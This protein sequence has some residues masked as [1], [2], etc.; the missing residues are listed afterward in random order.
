MCRAPHRSR[1]KKKKIIKK[2][3][4]S[5]CRNNLEGQDPFF[6]LIKKIHSMC[7]DCW[8][9][10]LPKSGFCIL[11]FHAKIKDFINRNTDPQWKNRFFL[12][13][14]WKYQWRIEYWIS[15]ALLSPPKTQ[16]QLNQLIYGSVHNFSFL[17]L[18]GS[19]QE[20]WRVFF[21][22]NDQIISKTFINSWHLLEQKETAPGDH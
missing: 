13:P 8:Q 16:S 11:R 4:I 21:L 15:K 6:I 19:I 22:P 10:F 9:I 12:V 17:A 7:C 2:A 1:I 20:H 14:G 18:I 5:S 3:T